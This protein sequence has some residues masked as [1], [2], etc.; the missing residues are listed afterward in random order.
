MSHLDA[1]GF[2]EQPALQPPPAAAGAA[3]R[4]AQRDTL[5]QHSRRLDWRYLLHD[6]SLRHVALLGDDDPDLVQALRCHAGTLS[7]LDLGWRFPA[8]HEPRFDLVVLRSPRLEDAVHA[9]RLVELG[10]CMYWEIERR[11]SRKW[12]A[13]FRPWRF[14]APARR[15]PGRLVRLRTHLAQ[16]GFAHIGFH[17][18]RPSF[19]GALEIV[20]LEERA[21]LQHV[22][23]GGAG[24]F[25]GNAKRL[26]ARLMHRA[27]LLQGFV[28]CVSV[29]ACRSACGEEGA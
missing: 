12:S 28:D 10:G 2:S 23:A 5:L 25:S 29:V 16:L 22:L 1:P 11:S 19:Q 24:R 14:D 26:L 18:H 4:R 3:D 13:W 9:S 21:I 7:L 27:G 17:W 20:P 15:S 6:S 8:G